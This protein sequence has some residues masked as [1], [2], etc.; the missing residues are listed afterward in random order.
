MLP[1]IT[2]FF[3]FFL[4][5]NPQYPQQQSEKRILENV[6][7]SLKRKIGHTGTSTQ[8]LCNKTQ[9]IPSRCPLLLLTITEMFLT[10]IV[11]NQW[12]IKLMDMLEKVNT[13]LLKDFSGDSACQNMG[14][15]DCLRGSDLEA[16]IHFCCI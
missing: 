3:F 9:Q 10:L 5:V 1:L 8:S 2:F 4:L 11:V 7:N 12:Q 13:C 14:S 6:V 15:R 16:T